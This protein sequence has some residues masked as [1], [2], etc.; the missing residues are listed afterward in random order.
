MK[1]ENQVVSGYEKK[2]AAEG[3]TVD[4]VQYFFQCTVV[5]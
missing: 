2:L 3:K 4:R 5:E 1:H